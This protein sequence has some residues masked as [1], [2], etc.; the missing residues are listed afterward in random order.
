MMPSPAYKQDRLANQQRDKDKRQRR[1]HRLD[2]ACKVENRIEESVNA[3]EK[4]S[5]AGTKESE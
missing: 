5:V 1:E 3:D 2:H 4:A